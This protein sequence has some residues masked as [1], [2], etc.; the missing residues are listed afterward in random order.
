MTDGDVVGTDGRRHVEVSQGKLGRIEGRIEIEVVDT[1]EKAQ[2]GVAGESPC[3]ARIV[4]AGGSEGA[5]AAAQQVENPVA[6]AAESKLVAQ[7]SLIGRLEAAGEIALI[8][9]DGCRGDAKAT[10][11]TTA[12]AA[13]SGCCRNE[14]AH[15]RIGV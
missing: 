15:A 11:A 7:V 6:V 9:V 8:E 2:V 3:Q 5:D 1:H 14:A 10:T 12:A 13:S 4:A